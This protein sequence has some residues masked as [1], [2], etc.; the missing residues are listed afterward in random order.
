METDFAELAERL[1]AECWMGRA[2]L[3]KLTGESGGRVTSKGEKV[4]NG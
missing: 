4:G 3:S 1:Q 2:E